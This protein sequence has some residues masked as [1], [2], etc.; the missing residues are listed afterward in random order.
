MA[1][2][3]DV[4][5]DILGPLNV[6]DRMEGLVKRAIY[7]DTAVKFTILRPRKGGNHTRD[8]VRII[9]EKYGVATFG[10]THDGKHINFLVKSRQAAWAEYLLLNAGV[11]LQNPAIDPNNSRGLEQKPP[12]WM[13]TPW[14]EQQSSD[15]PSN[16]S[17]KI[18]VEN[19]EQG[20]SMGSQFD[21]VLDR[22]NSI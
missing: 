17:G 20:R 12:G 2:V 9:L 5:D 7:R 8:D 3:F 15:H 21:K 14:S 19:E 13:P 4:L 6:I 18:P 16:A 11:D 10:H 1:N 22:I